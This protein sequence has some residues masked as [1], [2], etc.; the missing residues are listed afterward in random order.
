MPTSD[1]FSS[2]HAYTYGIKRV[3]YHEDWDIYV[4]EVVKLAK[5]YMEKNGV[6]HDY[7]L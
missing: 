1:A 6:P 3:R 5:R 2:F 4:K 7:L